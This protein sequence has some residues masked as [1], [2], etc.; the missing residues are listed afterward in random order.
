MNKK[1]AIRL[2]NQEINTLKE[3]TSGLS[4]IEAIHPMEIDLAISKIT[5]IYNLLSLLKD[6]TLSTVKQEINSSP[7]TNISKVAVNSEPI[8]KENKIIP[9]DTMLT[10]NPP[11]E[12][13]S[14]VDEIIKD[15]DLEHKLLSVENEAIAAKINEKKVEPVVLDEVKDENQVNN[16]EIEQINQPE[17]EFAE[18][19]EPEK[20]DIQISQT[21]IE[22]NEVQN[23]ILAD[24]FTEKAL[25]IN[26]MLSSFENDKNLAA[27]LK[28]R[29]VTEL[30]K[31]IKLNDRIWYI[32]ELFENNTKA[33]NNTIDNI[34]QLT[35]LD[36]ALMYLFETFNWDQNK[37]STIS[38]LEL[39][40][41]RFSNL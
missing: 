28:D 21:T 37:K 3:I 34:D 40:Y 7:P 38:F 25:S 30:K 6:P 23:G 12:T 2:I 26:D 33:Y 32:K 19:Q 4:D 31:A 41:R 11:V 39:I 5:D 9:E 15:G 22:N 17:E 10:T 35:T 20:E 16:I 8:T 27:L 14:T 29:P 18:K 13:N 1:I 24:K 36:E